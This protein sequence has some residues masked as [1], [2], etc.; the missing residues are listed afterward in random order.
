MHSHILSAFRA[1][2][3]LSTL[4]L[5][6]VPAN[7]RAQASSPCR[8]LDS[9]GLAVLK[10]A[11]ARATGT[12]SAAIR[13]RQ[14]LQLPAVNANRVSFIT[15]TTLCQKAVDAYAVAAGIPAT[16]LSVYLVKV[17]N[18]YVISEPTV[19]IGEWWYSMTAD[20]KFKILVKFTG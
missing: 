1:A 13:S 17:G 19:L 15:D 10:S 2:L 18:R 7:L 8:P 9:G 12:D 5:W 6:A 14:N 11:I 4:L 16:G 3:V 20:R